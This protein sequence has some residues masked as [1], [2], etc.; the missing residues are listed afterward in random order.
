MNRTA[1]EKPSPETLKTMRE[2]HRPGTHWAAFQAH[3]LDS[4]DLHALRFLL[5]GQGCTFATPPER[6]PDTQFG[7]GWKYILIGKVNL[8]TGQIEA[9]E[10][11]S[12]QFS[13]GGQ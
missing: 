9:G 1:D 8:E 11:V 10:T 6:Y 5:V 2:G 4:A 13:E 12:T 3:A 7:S